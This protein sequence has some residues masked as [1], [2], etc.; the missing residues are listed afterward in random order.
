[1]NNQNM[2]ETIT[3][4]QLQRGNLLGGGRLWETCELGRFFTDDKV[5]SQPFAIRRLRPSLELDVVGLPTN[6]GRNAP[7]L[8][9]VE[10]QHR[11]ARYAL[12]ELVTKRGEIR[13]QRDDDLFLILKMRA[14][15]CQLANRRD[16]IWAIE[17]IFEGDV[18][19]SHNFFA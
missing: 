4:S 5:E 2:K 17:G 16:A 8:V 14:V 10:D 13:I 3:R 7:S 6:S 15:Q 1:M 18:M 11:T 9:D 12:D 19:F